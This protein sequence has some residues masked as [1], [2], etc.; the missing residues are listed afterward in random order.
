MLAAMVGGRHIYQRKS[1]TETFGKGSDDFR[2]HELRHAS[3][4]GGHKFPAS[5]ERRGRAGAAPRCDANDH[6]GGPRSRRPVSS[7]HVSAP[8]IR[9]G[10]AG[11]EPTSA[12]DPALTAATISSRTASTAGRPRLTRITALVSTPSVDGM[13]RG[14]GAA[15]GDRNRTRLN[16][17]HPAKSYAVFCL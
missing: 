6:N 1:Q 3:V 14:S 2:N 8:V 12:A 15:A 10:V 13:A 11:A 9:A 16:S 7:S 5:R 4:N 17:S